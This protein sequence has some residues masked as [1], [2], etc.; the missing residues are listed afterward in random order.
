MKLSLLLRPVIKKT[1]EYLK[2]NQILLIT[3]GIFL[4]AFFLRTFNI[5]VIPDGLSQKEIE[6]VRAIKD[7]K[8]DSMW[9]EGGYYNA[10]YIYLSYLWS[11]IFGL[12]VLSL[13]YLSALI[14][15][16]TV[17]LSYVFIYKWFSRK[18]A[19]FMALLF[20]F[21]AFHVSASRLIIP[22]VLLPLVLVSLLIALTNAYRTKSVWLFGL[23]GVIAG[24]G[25]YTS[26]SFLLA[27]FIF[28]AAG[29][30]FFRRNKKFI[31]GYRD[32][33]IV[34]TVGF[35][36]VIAPYIVSFSLG[37]ASYLSYYNFKFS[38]EDLA[39]NISQ[40]PG[41]LFLKSS[42]ENFLNVGHEPLLDPLI[43][44]TSVAGLVF[45][46]LSLSRR[47]YFFL[48]VWFLIYSFY[49]ALRSPLS[50]ID[51]L[52]MLPVV[53]TFS[54]LIIELVLTKWFETFPIDK[55]AKFFAI[56]LVAVFFS[57][58]M[59]YNFDRY[60]VAYRYSK[61]VQA[62]FSETSPIPIK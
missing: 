58:S 33:L 32:E 42:G 15:G 3:L 14:G 26:P 23:S 57:L 25:F 51:L 40:I 52:G 4:F 10:A 61:S 55:K 48:V 6:T 29:F 39:I 56:G 9:L 28:L 45:A 2:N 16:L 20:S 27:P 41:L 1:I 7:L 5:R 17:L 50:G 49:A 37:S 60:F 12:S 36:A 21:S 19:I 11:K 62:E 22:E 30:Y 38:L 46:I 54:A 13:R 34:A 18:I 59:L 53:Y 8:K 35:F 47:K 31:T 43:F 44:V 24:L